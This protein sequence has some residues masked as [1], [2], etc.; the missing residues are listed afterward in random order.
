MIWRNTE[1][2]RFLNFSLMTFMTC[3]VWMR[4]NPIRWHI[5]D[6]SLE[7]QFLSFRTSHISFH[8]GLVGQIQLLYTWPGNPI[9]S[10]QTILGLDQLNTLHASF[11][12]VANFFMQNFIFGGC[13]IR[14]HWF[15]SPWGKMIAD[16]RS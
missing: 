7:K 10:I 4:V 12:I 2:A 16:L 11:L 8:I 6:Q 3:L 13:A 5:P 1:G 15:Q 14:Q 9:T